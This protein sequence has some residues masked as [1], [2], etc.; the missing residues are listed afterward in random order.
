MQIEVEN[1]SDQC[2]T[3]GLSSDRLKEQTQSESI[4][5]KTRINQEVRYTPAE[6]VMAGR[7]TA[8]AIPWS[9]YIFTFDFECPLPLFVRERGG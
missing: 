5:V 6:A 4:S 2:I 3:Q 1:C 8:A 9:L 7:L